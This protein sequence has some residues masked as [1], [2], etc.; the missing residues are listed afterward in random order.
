LS[1]F[2]SARTPARQSSNFRGTSNQLITVL[3]NPFSSRLTLKGLN[4]S[5]AYS[6]VLYNSYGQAVYTCEVKNKQVFEMQTTRIA[7]GVYWLTIYNDKKKPIGTQK[8]IK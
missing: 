2:L 1:C 4:N 3:P 7:W 6:I 8:V 5:K